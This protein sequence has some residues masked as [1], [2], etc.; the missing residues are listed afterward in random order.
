MEKISTREKIL[1]ESM[2]LFSV[3]GFNAVSIRNIA[4]NVGVR[5]SALYKHF[6]SKQEI[7]DVIV[8]K[9]RERFMQQYK[10]ELN[11]KSDEFNIEEVCLDMFRFQTHDEWVVQF[12]QMLIIEQFSNKR[13]AEVYKE[14]FVDMPVMGT[15]K[16]FENLIKQGIM[17]NCD[18]YVMSMELYAPFFMFHTMHEDMEQLEAYFR[19]HVKNFMKNYFN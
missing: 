11:V 14:L 4:A 9:S 5:D 13:I 16:I 1:I 17:K 15:A 3:N 2:K 8:E 10:K 6:K 18:A 7:F 19:I 12:R